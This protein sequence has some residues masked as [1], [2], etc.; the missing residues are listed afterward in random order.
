VVALL[1]MVGI[2]LSVLIDQILGLIN[3]VVSLANAPEGPTLH[4]KGLAQQYELGWVFERFSEQ[5]GDIRSQ[6]GKAASNVLLSTGD[7]IVSAAGFVAA[8]VTIL[9]ITFFL[10][11][12]GRT[13]AQC[14]GRALCGDTPTSSC[15]TLSGAVRGR[16]PATLEATSPSV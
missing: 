8:L 6:L 7:V 10:I 11:L 14:W 15:A 4:L 5:L 12:G 1:F 2:L 9:T 13:V 3:F 16:S